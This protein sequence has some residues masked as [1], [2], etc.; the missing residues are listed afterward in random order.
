M[1]LDVTW[2]IS[3]DRLPVILFFLTLVLFPTR[4]SRQSITPHTLITIA[5]A[6]TDTHTHLAARIAANPFL[7]VPTQQQDIGLMGLIARPQLLRAWQ[8]VSGTTDDV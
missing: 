5:A 3:P 4:S 2:L 6:H 7:I 1:L 8:G